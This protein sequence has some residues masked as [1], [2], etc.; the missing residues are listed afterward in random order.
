MDTA[1]PWGGIVWGWVQ[2]RHGFCRFWVME[3]DTVK[4]R[5]MAPS[6][7]IMADAYLA[8]PQRLPS[9]KAAGIDM[10]SHLKAPRANQMGS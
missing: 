4:S 5:E 2:V 1:E 7:A 6:M 10:S 3:S 8:L 9:Q